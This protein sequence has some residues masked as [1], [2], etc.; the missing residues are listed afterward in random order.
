MLY[1]QLK[2]SVL[3]FITSISCCS[4]FL[5]VWCIL[6]VFFTVHMM[7][8]VIVIVMRP[9]SL[10]GGRISRRTLSVRLSVCPSVCPSVPLSLPSVTSF[11][12][13][14]ASRMYFSARTD[15][16]VLFG[17]H[18]GSHI[19]RPSRPHRFLLINGYMMMIVDSLLYCWYRKPGGYGYGL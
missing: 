8:S 7:R 9:S 11:R 10:G 4:F 16:S 3:T 14:L 18:W 15:A 6:H 5:F 17:T 1:K 2:T 13:P 12:Q 19:V